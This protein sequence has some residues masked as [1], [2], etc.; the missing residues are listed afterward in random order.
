MCIAVRFR[1]I[2]RPD[3]LVLFY[4]GLVA[5]SAGLCGCSAEGEPGT[6]EPQGEGGAFSRQGQQ[7][8]S[9]Y[10]VW[11]SVRVYL[12]VRDSVVRLLSLGQF[13]A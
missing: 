10:S 2:S 13:A 3:K 12:Y 1:S 7:G 11:A 9:E 4:L 6:D 5:E 8:Q